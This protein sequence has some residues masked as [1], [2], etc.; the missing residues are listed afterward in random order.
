MLNGVKYLTISLVLLLRAET[1][2]ALTVNDSDCEIGLIRSLKQRMGDALDKRLP[3][4]EL[5]VTAAILNPANVS[6]SCVHLP[7]MFLPFGYKTMCHVA[8]TQRENR[9]R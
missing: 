9:E 1:K 7:L 2:Q 3:A 4:N 8:M 6:L 5:Y